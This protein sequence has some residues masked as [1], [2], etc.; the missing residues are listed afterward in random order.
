MK[1]VV[2][3]NSGL[4]RSQTPLEIFVITPKKLLR[5][6]LIT[7]DMNKFS[8]KIARAGKMK[9]FTFNFKKI[10]SIRTRN[11]VIPFYLNNQE[12]NFALNVSMREDSY[13]IHIINA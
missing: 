5:F 8:K 3:F 12:I 7:E 2:Q 11:I 9:K 1:L 10:A 6:C 4:I 13:F